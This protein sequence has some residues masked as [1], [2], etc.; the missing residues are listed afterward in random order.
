MA[1]SYKIKTANCQ[2]DL[3]RRATLLKRGTPVCFEINLYNFK[4]NVLIIKPF[5]WFVAHQTPLRKQ[6]S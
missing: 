5:P 2:H 3:R 6:Y 1:R 4:H